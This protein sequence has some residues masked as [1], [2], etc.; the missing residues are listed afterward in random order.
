MKKLALTGLLVAALLALGLMPNIQTTASENS[1]QVSVM[2]ANVPSVTISIGVPEAQAFTVYGD[3]SHW[4]YDWGT[5][6]ENVCDFLGLYCLNTSQV[7]PVAP[8][9]VLPNKDANNPLLA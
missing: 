9:F 2:N 8:Q 5:L 3:P 4:S 7:L 6:K 1:A